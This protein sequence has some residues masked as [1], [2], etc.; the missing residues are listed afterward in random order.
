[1]LAAGTHDG[2]CV[3]W[4]FDTKGIARNLLGHIKPVSSV[5]YYF[6]FYNKQYKEERGRKKDVG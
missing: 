6:T 2:R 3:V 4:D 1:M 5:R